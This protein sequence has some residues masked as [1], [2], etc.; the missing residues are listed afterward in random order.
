MMKA[1]NKK[2]ELALKVRGGI[3]KGNWPFRFAR[4]FY[5]I[6]ALIMICGLVVITTSQTKGLFRC[7]SL[8]VTFDEEIWESANVV[9]D[10]DGSSTE[11]ELL[12][13]SWFTGTYIENGVSYLM[14]FNLKYNLYCKA[15]T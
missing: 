6:N 12:I 2:H 4:I 11:T 15:N 10:E 8:T 7:K 14:M 9:L 1:T 13:Y 3:S 5:F